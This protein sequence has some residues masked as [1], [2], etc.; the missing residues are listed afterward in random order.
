M[1]SDR[2]EHADDVAAGKREDDEVGEDDGM[3]QIVSRM[4]DRSERERPL[5]DRWTV[6]PDNMDVLECAANGETE[7]AADQPG[8]DDEDGREGR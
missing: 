1:R 7:R 5:D 8:A 6:I 3:V 4:L 2:V